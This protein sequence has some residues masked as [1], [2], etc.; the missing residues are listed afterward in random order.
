MK[1]IDK[2]MQGKNKEQLE[3]PTQQR[4]LLL[5]AGTDEYMERMHRLREF[6]QSKGDVVACEIFLINKETNRRESIIDLLNKKALVKNADYIFTEN[7][8]ALAESYSDAVSI[9][10][11]ILNEGIDFRTLE[12][13]EKKLKVI[14]DEGEF[15]AMNIGGAM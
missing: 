9:Y 1:K 10:N 6:V 14:K 4:A 12:G 13:D 2:R 15:P 11:D 5:V 3:L 7:F 8:T